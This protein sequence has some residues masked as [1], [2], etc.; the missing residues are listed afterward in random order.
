[1]CVT[2]E[3]WWLFTSTKSWNLKIY[4]SKYN[5]VMNV[6]TLAEPKITQLSEQE[7]D[8]LKKEI[9]ELKASIRRDCNLVSLFQC[10]VIVVLKLNSELVVLQPTWNTG[11]VVVMARLKTWWN[12]HD[13]CNSGL[14]SHAK[15]EW[16]VL[17]YGSPHHRIAARTNLECP[18]QLSWGLVGTCIWG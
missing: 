13:P 1:M 10:C 4:N 5:N 2:L 9:S 18:N 12:Q 7:L 16:G 15:L 8:T 3:Y 6:L 17:H 11:G 14:M